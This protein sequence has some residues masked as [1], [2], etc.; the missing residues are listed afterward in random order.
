MTLRMA[1]GDDCSIVIPSFAGS[2]TDKEIVQADAIASF[3]ETVCP[4]KFLPGP[5]RF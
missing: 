4:A 1:P 3:A 2:P 5:V